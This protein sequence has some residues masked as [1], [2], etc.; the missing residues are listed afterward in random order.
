M[1]KSNKIEES[2]VINGPI[3]NTME[4]ANNVVWGLVRKSDFFVSGKRNEIAEYPRL[5]LREAINNAFFHNDYSLPGN[6]F[7]EMFPDRLEVRN[8]GVPL[9]GTR[10]SDLVSK[11]KHRNPILLKILSEM[12]FVEG[13]GIGLK[14]IID[15]LRTNGLP[16]P[17]LMVSNEETCLCF[18][19]HSFLD[20]ET[21]NWIT[22]IA[23]GTPLEMNLHQILA[24]AYTKRNK[25]ITNALYQHINGVS[26]HVAGNELGELCSS[27]LFVSLGRGKSA[28]YSLT[29]LYEP[30][31][32]SLAKYFPRVVVLSLRAPQ[33]KI[34]S[35]V[36]T[37]GMINAKQIFYQSGYSDERN[38]KRILNGLVKL[39]LCNRMAKSSSDPNAYYEINKEYNK[40]ITD[41]EIPRKGLQLNM[42]DDIQNKNR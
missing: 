29:E 42:F 33:R 17:K 24:L 6:I 23:T 36:S 7:I 1:E 15:N 2:A 35:L 9:G 28:Y 18:R 19:T 26:T 34:L 41:I 39:R 22:N 11:P 3:L 8:M 5:A 20:K 14:T 10:L 21:L 31:E 25:K 30:N 4:K 32:I 12:G 16:E 13:W 27:G 40:T 37:F 38:V